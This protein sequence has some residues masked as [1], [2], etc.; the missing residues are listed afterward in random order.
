MKELFINKTKCTEKEYNRFL[1]SYEKEYAVSELV[2]SLLY[3]AFW[4]LCLVLAILNKE[5]I[6]T[7]ILILGLSLYIWYKFIR[8]MKKVE[9]QKNSKKIINEYINTYKFYK[10]YFTAENEEGHSQIMYIKIYKVI[11]TE[12]H[13]YI[14]ISRE[15]AFIVAKSGFKD[16]TNNEFKDF[17][18]KKAFGKYKSQIEKK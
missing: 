10:H 4:I 16:N 15:Y 13:F 14:Y 1:K 5:Y 9:K 8:P 6:L 12:T 11:E 3:I 2:R 17:I 18:K 7:L